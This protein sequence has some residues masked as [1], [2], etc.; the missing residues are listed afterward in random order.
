MEDDTEMTPINRSVDREKTAPFLIRAFVKIG[1]FHRT[2]LFEDRTS[3]PL[4]DEHQIFTWKDASLKELLTTLREVAPSTNEFRHPLA[5]YAFKT[6]YADSTQRGAFTTKDLGIVYSRDILGEPGA[7]V[8]NSSDDGAPLDS[9]SEEQ[10]K[11]RLDKS[12]EDLRFVP[13]DYLLVNIMM[14]KVPATTSAIKNTLNGGS[15]PGKWGASAP[16]R[17]AGWNAPAT[18]APSGGASRGGGHWRA[19]PGVAP[20]AGRATTDRARADRDRDETRGFPGFPGRR[21]SSPRGGGRFGAGRGRERFRDSDRVNRDRVYRNRRS[22]SRSRS[23]APRSRSRSRTPPRR[24][25]SPATRR[26]R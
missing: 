7:L 13:G 21:A 20:P 8:T 22:P 12:L 2:T 17:D 6:L 19:R 3:I 25:H 24:S 16:G 26:K 15:G 18:P 5:R 9:T 14:P 23:R 4:T 11:E 10:E 1:G